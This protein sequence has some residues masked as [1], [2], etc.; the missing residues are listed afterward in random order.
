MKKQFLLALVAVCIATAYFTL[1]SGVMT[2]AASPSVSYASDVQ[3]IFETRCDNCHM[4]E[5]PSEG[6]GL[7]AYETLMA[8][9][10]NG[11]VV[12]PGNAD[13]SL[14]IEK[15]VEGEMPKRGP[16]LTPAQI[17]TLIDWINAGASNN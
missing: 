14:L 8:G 9:S 15:V 17:Q 12:I 4:G 2:T 13:D 6:L 5:Y 16:K 1:Q 10:Q 11:P 7:D 3:P